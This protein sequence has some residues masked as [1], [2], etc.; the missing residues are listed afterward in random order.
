[1][2]KVIGLPMTRTLRVLWALEELGLPY[3]LDPAKPQSDEARAFNPSGKVPALIVDGET[4]TDSVAIMTFLADKHGGLTA[5]AGTLARAHQDAV[6]NMLLDEMDA[7]L[8]MAARHSFIL[9][10]ERRV[11][12]IKDSLQWEFARSLERI[13]AKLTGDFIAGDSFTIADILL[14]HCLRWA[15]NAK[16]EIESAALQDYLARMQGRDAF[17]RLLETYAK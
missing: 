10:E 3:E 15:H 5:P 1:M 13:E 6:T 9:P 4:I 12:E 11:P 16:F 17:Q 8:W 2:Y 14:T 7:I